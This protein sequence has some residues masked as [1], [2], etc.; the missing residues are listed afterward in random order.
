MGSTAMGDGATTTGNFSTAMG[1]S[2]HAGGNSSTAM[3]RETDASGHM[4]TAMGFRS[5]AS[6]ASSTAMGE[7]ST[8]SGYLSFAMGHRAQATN[9][10]TFV[11]ADSEDADFT[12]TGTNQF[13]IRASGGVG[14]N[15][16]S[17]QFALHV[18]GEAGKPG[19][20]AWSV[21]S[22]RGSRRT[23][24]RWSKPSR[25]CCNCTASPTNTKTPR[26]FTNCPATRPA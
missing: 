25:I 7:L 11:W 3:G 13:L 6:G 23:S 14:I 10:G 19:G 16:D 1:H 18:N 2:T 12:S 24:A 21:A 5:I 4:S 17:P 26:R 8:A 20:G 15:T 22:M 9:D